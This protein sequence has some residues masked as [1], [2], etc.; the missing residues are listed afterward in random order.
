MTTNLTPEQKAAI[1]IVSLGVDK[2]SKIYK[3]LS[4]E[5]IEKLTVEVAKLGHVEADATEAVLDD[6]YKT[7][8]C[9][10]SFG[11]GVWR[12]HCKQPASKGDSVLKIQIFWFH[13][14]ERFKELVFCAAA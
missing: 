8:L 7:C 3:Y 11:K 13:Q 12:K 5:D 9:K 4:E 10:N 6:F 2:A 14:K 1:V